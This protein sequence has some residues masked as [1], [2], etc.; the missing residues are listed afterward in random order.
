MNNNKLLILILIIW[1][2]LY[3]FPH[4]FQFIEM[5]NDFELLYYSYKK[6]IFEF[7][8]VGH[9][10]LWSPS[11]SSG[12]SLIFNPFA[13][14][15]YP[16]SWLLYGIC[17]LIGDL[18]KHTYLMYTIIGLSI[19]NLGQYFWLRSI[20][21]E[22]KYA[23]LSTLITCL[24]LKLTE[25]LRF[26]NAVHTI[27]WFPWILFAISIASNKL[28]RI[29][30]SLIIF[31]CS[32]MIFTAGYPY[33]IFYALIL[34]SS[35]FIFLLIPNVK[36]YVLN[37]EK[38]NKQNNYYFFLNCFLPAL[39]ALII[40][41]PWFTRIKNL[42]EITRDRNLHEID[43]SITLSSN[44]IDQIGSWI[45]P[46]F[47]LSE[48]WYYFGSIVT[49]L[50]LI[51]LINF[52]FDKNKTQ[53]EKYII[54]FSFF[55]FILNYQFAAAENS[56]LFKIIWNHVDLIKNFRSWSR[57]NIILIP[58]FALIISL[59]LK[60]VIND[61][62]KINII[63]SIL[64]LTCLIVVAQ[65]YFIEFSNIENYYWNTWQHKRI[66]YAS[67]QLNYLS[68]FFGLYNSYI[69]SIFFIISAIGLIFFINKKLFSK[70]YLLILL[71][72]IG[73]LFFITNIQWSIPSK[74][75]DKNDYNKLSKDPINDLK[76]AFLSNNLITV[77]KG[78]LY[79]RNQR[80]FNINYFDEF[81][82]EAH[83]KLVDKYFNRYGV[84]KNDLTTNEFEKIKFFWALDNHE[85]KIFFSKSIDHDNIFKFMDDVIESE[86]VGKVQINLIESSYNGDEI[87]IE[88]NSLI[89][90]YITY[91]DNW[92]SGW[93]VKVN[94]QIKKIEKNFN[95]YKA[96]KINKGINAVFYKYHPWY[97]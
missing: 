8:R 91:M 62:Y 56:F 83:T 2:Y 45:F 26:P 47:S 78:N 10:P 97:D 19:Y 55:L 96:V 21:I 93:K 50:I 92:S 25:I 58:I 12:Y 52:L 6:Y 13:Q 22:K 94:D 79:F 16:V 65:I 76:S 3:L 77:T 49:I 53:K 20:N 46:P 51:Y 67:T 37:L 89:P 28:N 1:P 48:G 88:I 66:D 43:F 69:Y 7:V 68:F 64:I 82:I 18:S 9:F 14:Y 60:K 74:Y 32:L 87:L 72:T 86:K 29:K 71:L 90:G 61:K 63:P 11:E 44:I 57:M 95:T 31:S 40:V 59:S 70:I 81:G 15:F 73:E 24:G 39:L 34:F 54:Y 75:Y 23:F 36:K 4:T 30:S 33:Y 17:I 5:G 35:Y 27:A 84:P 41:S 80:K 85:R 38:I 42:M